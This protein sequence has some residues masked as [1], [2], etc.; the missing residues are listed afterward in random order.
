MKDRRKCRHDGCSVDYSMATSTTVLQNHCN[1]EHPNENPPSLLTHRFN[2]SSSSSSSLS[3]FTSHPKRRKTHQLTIEETQVQ[4]NN[5]A[6]RP[7]LAALLARCSWPHW[8][9]ELPEFIN[10]VN[11]CRASNCPPP[12][13]HIVPKDQLLLATQLR[14]RVVRHLKNYCRSS[15][16]SIAIDGWTNVNKGKVSNVVILCGGVAFY[17]CSIVNDYD[18]DTAEWLAGPLVSVLKQIKGEGLVFTSLVADNVNM[19][20]LLFRLLQKTFPFLVRSPCAAHLVQLCVLR[21]LELP[22]ID[23]L[24]TSMESL[25]RFFKAKEP[26]LKLKNVQFAATQTSLKLIRPCDTR[27]S[28]QLYAAQR[29]IKLRPYIDMVSQQTALFWSQLIEL[30]CFLKPFQ[31]AT[32]VMQQDASTLYDVYQQFKR[33]LQHV[34][35][36]ESTSIFHSSQSAIVNIIMKLWEKHINIEATVCCALLSF[37]GAADAIFDARI[38]AAHRWFR[39]F[40]ADYAVYWKI[41]TLEELP[42]VANKV[43]EEWSNFMGRVPGSCFDQLDDDIAQLRAQH[44][45]KQMSFNPKAVWNLYLADSHAPL[46]SHAAV[47]LLSVSASEAAVERTFSAQGLVH[48]DL[49]NRMSGDTVESEMFIKFNQ[50][51]MQKVEER[52][53]D[54]SVKSLQKEVAEVGD[55]E[56]DGQVEQDITSIAGVFRRMEPEGKREEDVEEEQVEEKKEDRMD[57]EVREAAV[58]P[59]V[60]HHVQAPPPEDDVQA[61]VE[62]FVRKYGV[63]SAGRWSADR[64][65]DLHTE[66]QKWDPP[67][68]DSDAALKRKI[69]AWVRAVDEKEEVEELHVDDAAS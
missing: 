27:W 51:T 54:R 58:G 15:P 55:E 7:A 24:L 17:W 59:V 21:A 60:I 25:I 16:L 46:I 36:L 43:T 67:M 5:S 49:R 52:T 14:V 28:S 26:R 31:I 2:S 12:H 48:S 65:N 8:A 63:N 38:P 22:F 35:A 44:A 20:K 53:M 37:D 33:L 19:N 47:A 11:A 34:K 45:A 50:R 57:E 23:P 69:M 29:L 1:S 68:R 39:K 9:V 10:F 6:F 56:D 30:T 64:W 66:G 32:D 62:H 61:F 13:R 4:I 18:H 42:L 41:T 3:D 40:A